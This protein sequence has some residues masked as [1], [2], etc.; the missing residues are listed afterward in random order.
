[1]GLG[2]YWSSATQAIKDGIEAA[3]MGRRAME[4]SS[5][6]E[7]SA[8]QAVYMQATH[9]AHNIAQPIL[10]LHDQLAQSGFA[11]EIVSLGRRSLEAI[12]AV[13]DMGDTGE[14]HANTRFSPAATANVTEADIQK[15][16][17]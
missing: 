11:D 3:N 6:V 9:E 16:I 15:V 14:A 13:M 4:V 10:S 5:S 1:M 2:D 8:S 17:R 12:D 7:E